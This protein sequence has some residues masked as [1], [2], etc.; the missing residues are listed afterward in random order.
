MLEAIAT[1]FSTI[2]VV[3]VELVFCN[4]LGLSITPFALSGKQDVSQS[5]VFDPT[6]LTGNY[7]REVKFKTHH[8]GDEHADLPN[9]GLARHSQ[10]IDFVSF[11]IRLG[12]FLDGC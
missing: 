6:I 1:E 7:L 3:E 12:E 4:D 10:P 8:T 11:M 5:V 2:G 9:V